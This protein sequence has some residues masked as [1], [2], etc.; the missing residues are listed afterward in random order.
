[1][2]K[3]PSPST[4]N[5]HPITV[6]SW[7][8]GLR[9][10][11]R[12]LVPIHVDALVVRSEGGAVADCRM[13]TPAE[14]GST[15]SIDLLPPPFADLDKPR[16]RGV[17]L[18]WAMPDGLATFRG[19][20][21]TASPPALPDRWLVAR[22]SPGAGGR[23]AITA[24]VI[25]ARAQRATP[26]ETWSAGPA[27]GTPVTALGIGDAGW[28]AYYDNVQNRFGFHD[29]LDSVPAGRI[30]YLVCGWYA[31]PSL[32]PLATGTDTLTAF[33]ARLA[34][35]RWD[36]PIRDLPRARTG[37]Q[38]RIDKVAAAGLATPHAA[39]DD[40]GRVVMPNAI[41]AVHGLPIA[42]QFEVPQV[43]WP[44]DTLV[45]GAVVGLAWPTPADGSPEVGGPPAPD[46]VDVALGASP[47]DALAALIARA[48]GSPDEADWL[49]A[50]VLG[51][52]DELSRP[53]GDVRLADRLHDAVFASRSD[54]TEQVKRPASVMPEARKPPPVAPPP[55]PP[56]KTPPQKWQVS[57]GAFHDAHKV[58]PAPAKPVEPPEITLPRPRL[59]LPADP[60][61]AIQGAFRSPKHGDDG[62]FT[63][64]GRLMCRVSGTAI[65]TLSLRASASGA[66][67][68]IHASDILERPLLHGGVPPECEELL[69][70]L[71]LFDPGASAI[72]AE[73]ARATERAG[74]VL[75]A[76]AIARIAETEQTAWWATRRPTSDA[77]AIAALS[78]YTGTLPSPI[79][80]RP[81]AHPW[82]PLHLDWEIEYL[83]TPARDWTLGEVDF[84]PPA[85]PDAPGQRLRGRCLLSPGIATALAES[86]QKYLDDDAAAGGSAVSGGDHSA[87]ATDI[88]TRLRALDT[89][90]GPLE[91][92]H[93]LLRRDVAIDAPPGPAPDGLVAVRA[94]FARLSRLRLVDA[95]GQ[96]LDL[97]GSSA[98]RPADPARIAVGPGAVTPGAPGTVVL[99]PRFTAPT[100]ISFRFRNAASP[101]DDATAAA[102]PVVGFLL[103]DHLDEALELYDAQG[104]AIGQLRLDS[105]DG[106][107]WELAP[108]LPSSVGGAPELAVAQPDL[109]GFAQALL[110]H[111]VADRAAGRPTA[112]AE[113]LRA[114]DA[115]RWTVDPFA[116][117]GEEH[118]S[119]LIGH[120]VAVIAAALQVEVREPATGTDVP[121]TRVPV[122]LGAL[123]H[124]QDGLFGY[125]VDR[126]FTTLRCAA[127]A[128]AFARPLPSAGFLG[129][130]DEVP[131]Y[132]ASFADD[133]TGS[134][135]KTPID[136]PYVDA[137]GILWV[138]PGVTYDLLLLV[139]PHSVIHATTGLLPR[140]Q[141]APQ[142]EWLAGP[143]AELAP[144]FRFGPVLRDPGQVRMPIP[145]DIQ[146][147]WTWTHRAD[148]DRWSAED[149]IHAGQEALLSPDPCVANEGWLKLRPAPD[150]G[151]G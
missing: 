40:A 118:L 104:A 123:T 149:I 92:F 45:H 20:G 73:V 26:L 9:R 48:S 88:V 70:E 115:T 66:R 147:A 53:D 79:A 124:W 43:Y 57:A 51:A 71:G 21:A 146:G 74:D 125:Y 121:I 142:R 65:T 97:A 18:H 144:T 30:A 46:A 8:P 35:L 4:F 108:G 23:R 75:S 32:D 134:A 131:A 38:S 5:F 64:D 83:A 61:I 24:W 98:T 107:L 128:A 1:M 37:V 68:V 15:R 2:A 44:R 76:P 120:P 119:L 151:S 103:P 84:A 58:A 95:F 86:V 11:L 117:V 78:G 17:H 22:A 145:S 139:E 25:D 31:D 14:A 141:I 138:V 3:L 42:G 126:D 34:Q 135:G 140:K 105:D 50:F 89:L 33:E 116:H 41:A 55:R 82:V 49:D 94:G 96:V 137:S 47:A 130:V 93:R 113:L 148:V 112:L 19:E 106:P 27:T 67:A 85:V 72:I 91:G 114:I 100:K 10:E 16:P 62:R 111:S 29:P 150:K 136:H 56:A 77:R 39:R 6:A 129:P 12:L 87:E 13:R 36:V 69:E 133:V 101:G 54:G 60:V 28:A 132:A 143:L 102:S 81:A 63:P 80:V 7:D 122:R 59:F 110:D 109:A 99:P 52:L 127:A 90:Q